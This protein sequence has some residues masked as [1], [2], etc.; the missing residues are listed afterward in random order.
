MSTIQ[1]RPWKR[2]WRI[3]LDYKFRFIDIIIRT[4]SVQVEILTLLKNGIPTRIL[5]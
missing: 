2:T 5:S 3:G 1:R 4:C